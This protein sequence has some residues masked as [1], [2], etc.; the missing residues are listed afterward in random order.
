MN[1]DELKQKYIDE[2]GDE[3]GNMFYAVYEEWGNVLYHYQE[4]MGLFNDK[5]NVT[6]LNTFGSG[7][8]Y[9]QVQMG[10]A[11]ILGLCR[12]T[13]E[14]KY[15]RSASVR[16]L[17][18]FIHDKPALKKR[19]RRHASK[20]F[21]YAKAAR[22]RRNQWIAHRDIERKATKVTFGEIK[23]GLDSVYK[24]LNTISME[25]WKSHLV[26]KV[27]SKNWSPMSVL[28][29][30]LEF[31][32]EGVLFIDS[33]IDPNGQTGPYDE[34]VSIAFLNRFNM[35][36]IKEKDKITIHRLRKAAE[37]IRETRK[38]Q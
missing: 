25:Y 8:G 38:Q 19:V 35:D 3:F 31:L 18:K 2:L 12:L 9:I 37:I 27:E 5:E 11:L 21:K 28:L 24:A 22:K 4:Y 16:N 6:L 20:A 30:R 15:S 32:V 26:N 14:P 17:P 34:N 29:T 23:S 7:I 1:S 33:L 13:D 10:E 36:S